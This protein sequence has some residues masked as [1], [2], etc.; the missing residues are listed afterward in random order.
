MI[1]L[2]PPAE[3]LQNFFGVFLQFQ[4]GVDNYLLGH[5]TPHKRKKTNMR[6][7]EQRKALAEKLERYIYYA[8][9][10]RNPA[11][12]PIMAVHGSDIDLTPFP[13]IH[14]LNYGDE[15]LFLEIHPVFLRKILFVWQ[16]NSS[17]LCIFPFFKQR[18]NFF[19][20]NRKKQQF[21]ALLE[22]VLNEKNAPVPNAGAD[23]RLRHFSQGD[24]ETGQAKQSILSCSHLEQKVPW[25]LSI[26]R[27]F[28]R[29][30]PKMVEI[31]GIE[32]LT[33]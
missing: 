3:K 18:L 33:S 1:L 16:Q 32:P 15:P 21:F 4:I 14:I 6:L 8:S 29:F 28:Q 10:S 2:P 26:P 20:K 11:L 30:P 31:S 25:N 7:P 5:Q 23:F 22:L 27:N 13:S 17:P 9:I 24:C 12:E 19:C